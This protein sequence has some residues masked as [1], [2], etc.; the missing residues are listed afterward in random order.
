MKIAAIDIGTNAVKAKVFNTSPSHIEFIESNRSAMRL[1]TD[2]FI[3]GKLSNFND[4]TI[5]I[6][7]QLAI[8]LGVVVG[9]KINIMSS[10]KMREICI[11]AIISSD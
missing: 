6:G 10:I 9:T 7:K 4:G 2:V 8:E 3:D 11:V 1:G 5:I